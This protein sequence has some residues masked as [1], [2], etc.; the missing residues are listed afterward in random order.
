[1]TKPAERPGEL[2]DIGE[3]FEK[4]KKRWRDTDGARYLDT[5]EG[6]DSSS[7][8]PTA[9]SKEVDGSEHDRLD[10]RQVRGELLRRP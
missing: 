9:Q 4:A 10:R 8:G 3:I 1:M 2:M 7:A 6:A 5:V